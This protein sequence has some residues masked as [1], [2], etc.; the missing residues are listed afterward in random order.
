MGAVKINKF[1]GEAP[2]I[3]TELLPDG[4]AQTALNAK[5]YSG[6]LLPYVENVVV[7]SAERT[8]TIKTLYALRTPGT[9]VLKWS[10]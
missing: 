4:A 6:D 8:G 2:K 9:G 1:L 7:D 3:S 10:A 5:L